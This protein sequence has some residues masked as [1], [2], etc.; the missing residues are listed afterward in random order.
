MKPSAAVALPVAPKSLFE[1]L[2]MQEAEL[3]KVKGLDA[4]RIPHLS[5]PTFVT[6][7][8]HLC[9]RHGASRASLRKSEKTPHSSKRLPTC[10]CSL[11]PLPWRTGLK[12]LQLGKHPK[13]ALKPLPWRTGLK[14]LQLGKHPKKALCSL[15]PNATTEEAREADDGVLL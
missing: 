5:G 4:R 12:H 6:V 10:G 15:Q 7:T 9:C 3:I 14:H 13:K 11:K 2:E 1:F 8:G